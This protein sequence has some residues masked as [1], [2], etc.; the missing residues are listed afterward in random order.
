MRDARERTRYKVS[1]EIIRRAAEKLSMLNV[2]NYGDDDNLQDEESLS[3][4]VQDNADSAPEVGS[5]KRGRPEKLIT[6][7]ARWCLFED[8]P[9]LLKAL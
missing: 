7:G 1:K 6:P 3:A 4:T 2:I 8:A 9:G 5:G